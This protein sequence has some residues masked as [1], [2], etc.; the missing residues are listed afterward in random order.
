MLIDLI[1]KNCRNI[2]CHAGLYLLFLVL[3]TSVASFFASTLPVETS[4]ESHILENDSDL[5]FYEKFKN[6]LAKTNFWL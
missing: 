6:N 2:Y 3:L 4:L 1:T 5:L